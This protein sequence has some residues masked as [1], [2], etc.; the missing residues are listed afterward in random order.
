MFVNSDVSF[1][2]ENWQKYLDIKLTYLRLCDN[3]AR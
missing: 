1:G 3:E 2:K